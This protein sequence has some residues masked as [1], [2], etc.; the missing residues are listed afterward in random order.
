MAKKPVT[1]PKDQSLAPG[2]TWKKEKQPCKLPS[3]LHMG[4]PRQVHIHLVTRTHNKE[5]LQ[6]ARARQHRLILIT[7]EGAEGGYL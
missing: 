3:D 1:E 2:P 4:E 6:K 5:T 7:E